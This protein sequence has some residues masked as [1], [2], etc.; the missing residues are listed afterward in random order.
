MYAS[1]YSCERVAEA[2]TEEKKLLN[3]VI[4]CFLCP[5]KKY[6]RIAS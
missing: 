6:S 1:C 4:F 2:D 3:E 5:Q